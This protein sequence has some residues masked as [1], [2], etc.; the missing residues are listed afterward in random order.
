[1][2]ASANHRRHPGVAGGCPEKWGHA[3]RPQ[4]HACR[5]CV[6][7]Q[8][9]ERGRALPSAWRVKIESIGKF[10]NSMR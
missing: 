8:V 1:M 10:Q 3:L 4:I 5:G 2:K 9:V 6:R 7:R